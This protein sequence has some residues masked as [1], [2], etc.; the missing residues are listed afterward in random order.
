MDRPSQAERIARALGGA[1]RAGNGWLAFCPCHDNTDTPALSLSD[2]V[3]V[4][5]VYCH[6]L[7]GCTSRDILHELRRR[8]LMLGYDRRLDPV[9]RSPAPAVNDNAGA[10]L[11]IWG[12][13]V[14]I[15][16]TPAEAYLAS[17]GLRA[18]ADCADLRFHP[19]CPRG[20]LER[21]PAMVALMRD[22]VS[23]APSGVHRT[24]L[25]ADGTGKADGQAKMMLGNAGVLK[26]SPDVELGLGICEGIETGLA[27]VG[28]GWRPVWACLSAGGIERL[29][30]LAGI[31]SLTIFADADHAG[32]LAAATCAA[33]WRE[34]GREARI[35]DPEVGFKDFD[36]MVRSS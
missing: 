27:I 31:E 13:C 23:N 1:K 28:D 36:D 3:D 11:A 5:L 22:A 26:L 35:V 14:P 32:F 4:L 20:S 18:P 12:R 15:S 21:L 8:G 16:G 25:R 19:A 17:R 29:P 10:A 7:A 6:G 34:V 9:R 2:G 30:V 24:F 33:R